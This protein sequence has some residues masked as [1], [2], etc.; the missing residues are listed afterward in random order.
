VAFALTGSLRVALA[1]GVI[2]P[3]VQTVFFTLHDRIWSRIE[4]RRAAKSR[5][6]T[7]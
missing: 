5:P 6:A 7:A 4:A 2:E 1:I 3:V